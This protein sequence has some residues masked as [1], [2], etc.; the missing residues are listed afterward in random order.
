V[1]PF[2][3]A[4]GAL[5][6]FPSFS[7]AAERTHRIAL[8]D[9]FSQNFA[10]DCV[11]SPEGTYVAYTEMRWDPA[12][13]GR[14]YDI[15]VVHTGTRE[16][17]RLTFDPAR[18]D[19][20]LW[21]GERWVYFLGS[22]NRGSE[23]KAPYNGE[24]QV[25]RMSPEGGEVTA[26]TRE[27]E[28]VK[29]FRMSGD[30]RTLY[31]V[32]SKEEIGEDPWRDLREEFT[33]L[34]YGHGVTDLH[35]LWKLDLNT[36]RAEKLVDENRYIVEF[37]AAPDG[38]R[39]A[40]ITRP[41]PSLISNEG[42]S[43]VDLYNASTGQVAPLNDVMWREEAPSPFGWIL[44]LCW[45]SDGG[46]LAFRVDFDGYP[47]EVFV[48]D[49]T[50]G[51]PRLQ[52]MTRPGEVLVTQQMLWMPGSR[53]LCFAAEDHGR[54]RV[55]A[56]EGLA[57]GSQGGDYVL[58]PGDVAVDDFTFSKR[59]AFAALF[60]GM[61]HPPDVFYT[62]RARKGAKLE[63]LTRL[64]PQVD[65]WMLP[66][67]SVY[68]WTSRDGTP[69]EGVLELPPGHRPEDG[70]L[71]LM[72]NIHGGPTSCTL[73]PFRFWIY[74]QTVYAARGW[75]MLSPNYRGSTGYGDAFLTDLIGNKNNLD[76][77][78]ILS[79]VNALIAEGIADPERMAVQGWSNGGYLTNCLI[80]RD[81]RFKAASSGA[82]VFDTV[83]QWSIEDTPGHVINFSKGNLPWDEEGKAVMHRTS[84]LYDVDN[85]QTPTLIHVGEKDERVPVEH[86][87]SLYRALRYYLDVPVELVVYPGAGHTIVKYSHRK[88]KMEWDRR[89]FDHYVLEKKEPEISGSE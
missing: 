9:Y 38:S 53:T 63:R 88:A 32:V 83:M 2:L 42:W 86:S 21:G 13:D 20:P 39:I 60:S 30:G 41:D 12:E 8:D 34:E 33:D 31:Y 44:D 79:G 27:P 46:A 24:K 36:W 17:R 72:V 22:R 43:R 40:M 19:K 73:L 35:Q 66:Q 56:V 70:P 76:V 29:A 82:G 49:F 37:E 77:E 57:G 78:D 59:G 58:T 54:R 68:R 61:D 85:V 4:F 84:P 3:L 47:G 45:S 55:I 71:P 51:G 6:L 26:V 65:T 11:L 48:A 10:V 16:A 87:R 69:V 81:P 64:N 52:R 89:W 7:A 14:N 18:D 23:E 1:R 25:W 80:T 15:W 50:A 5:V 67:R 74:G 75:A 62:P 28:G